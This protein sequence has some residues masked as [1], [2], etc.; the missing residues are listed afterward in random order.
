MPV[1]TQTFLQSL[2]INMDDTTYQA[3]AEH[4]EATLDERVVDAVT[5]SLN[6]RQL[7]E[8]VALRDQDEARL[9]A[10]LQANVPDLNEIVQDEVDILLGELA[11]NSESI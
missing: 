3:F 10:W 9:Q 1:L 4:F 2:G 5:D 8:L 11:E 6:E 7:E